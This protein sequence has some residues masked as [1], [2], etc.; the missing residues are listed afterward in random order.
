[1]IATTDAFM[2]KLPHSLSSLW[3]VYSIYGECFMLA[4]EGGCQL[5]I[6]CSC[7]ELVSNVFEEDVLVLFQLLS[8]VGGLLRGC[9]FVPH[10]AF[11][12]PMPDNST[13]SAGR[14]SNPGEKLI[15]APSLSSFSELSSSEAVSALALGF[16]LAGRPESSGFSPF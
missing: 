5:F 14:A 10:G 11:S 8:K 15:F 3:I 7:L 16:A 2:P 12:T 13:M 4:S 6:R 1:M 9:L